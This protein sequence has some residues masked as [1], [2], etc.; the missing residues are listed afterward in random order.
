MEPVVCQYCGKPAE[1]VAGNVMYPS[2]P[3]LAHRQFYRC[4]PCDAC[5]GCHPT[6]GL[7]LGTLANRDLR[8]IRMAAHGA[9]DPLWMAGGVMT[10]TDA[11]KWLA[12][13]LG[14]SA[15][16]CHIGMF[17]ENMCRRTIEKCSKINPVT[18]KPF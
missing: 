5:V 12:G 7:A 17:D 2:R 1:K 8:R 13:E 15:D 11:Y 16:D 4:L 18:D 3:D 10:R 14:V 9:F 6:T